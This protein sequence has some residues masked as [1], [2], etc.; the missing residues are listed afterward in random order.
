MRTAVRDGIRPAP[1]RRGAGG[2]ATGAGT[3]ISADPIVETPDGMQAWKVSYW[4][5]SGN[6]RP[7]Q[8]TGIVA[9][10]REAI[11]AQPRKV[12]A[13]THGTW[14]VVSK[15][16]PS[17][18]P[19][20][21]ERHAGFGRGGGMAMSSL[22]PIIPASARRG[23]ASLPGRDRYRPVGDRRGARRGQIPGAAAGNR[24]AVWGE[25]QGGHAAL[26]TA[27]GRGSLCA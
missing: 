22:R 7:V 16:A 10:P 19:Q 14:G 11:P 9:A 26:W 24:Y 6:G 20:F 2:S 23:G 5:S 25:S 1:Q 8:A 21:L 13:W 27:A 3:L 17:G 4:T 15:C 18:E 12:L